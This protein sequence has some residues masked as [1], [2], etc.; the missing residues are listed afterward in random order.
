MIISPEQ[1]ARF[2]VDGFTEFA[3]LIDPSLIPALHIAFDELFQ[4]R[5]ATGVSPD[6]VNWQQG[7]GDPTVTRQI[8]NGWKA[9]KA[10]ARVVLSVELGELVAGLTGW[11]GVRIMQDNVLWKP[12][13]AKALGYHQDSAYL[14]WFRPSDLCSVWIALDDTHANGG[15][16]EF[17]RGSHNWLLSKPE[18]EFHAPRQYRNTM[19]HAAHQ[20]GIVPDIFYI[21]VP[22]GGGSVHHGYTWHGS[23]QNNG[24]T[25]RRALV[26]HAMQSEVEYQP[27]HFAEGI[28]PV[29]SRYRRLA[30][31]KMD[32]NHFP[33]L[34]REDG[35]RTPG[36]EQ[37]LSVD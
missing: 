3:R 19:E 1:L 27:E 34:W 14:S 35:Y 20:A 32:E 36:L 2:E 31:N 4:G 8:C 25:P 12:P 33:V 16:L 24:L 15:T 28:G 11:S 22:A 37:F 17:V 9:N 10:I 30:D 29:Y 5:F 13:G 21:E 18:G 23:G 7:N 6:E 26:L